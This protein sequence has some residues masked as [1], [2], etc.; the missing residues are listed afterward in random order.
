MGLFKNV[1]MQGAQKTELRGVHVY[2]LSGAVCSATQQMSVFQQPQNNS[3][4]CLLAISG[5]V[6]LVVNPAAWNPS[7]PSGGEMRRNPREVAL[8]SALGITPRR[9][10]PGINSIY[11]SNFV[12]LIF[13][14]C[15]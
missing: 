5:L 3:F 7:A 11:A 4:I 14:E 1:Q 2:K 12:S 9:F 15:H 6:I 13:G 10:A 8:S